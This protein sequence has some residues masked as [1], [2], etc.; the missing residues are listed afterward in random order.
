MKTKNLLKEAIIWLIIALP[1]GYLAYVWKDLPA[2]IPIHYGINGQPDNWTSPQGL[3]WLTLSM[4]LGVYLLM[5][6]I[7]LIDPKQKITKMGTKYFA[8]KLL[9]TAFMSAVAFILIYTSVKTE[10]KT[11]KLIAILMGF[12]MV[13][14]GN[15]MPSFKPNYFIGVR[16]PW[17][18][19]SEPN[20]QATHRFAGWTWV[21]TGLFVFLLA[22]FVNKHFV[23]QL[24]ILLIMLAA[25]API[26]YSF[27][28][29]LRNKN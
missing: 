27:I 24:S 12:L 20:W 26:V 18:L 13:V 5:C 29:Y 22:L 28:Y 14:F 25:L 10:I 8:V 16:T 19:E 21:T 2:Q 6:I 11:E 3:I 1:L 17:T 4:T 7:P 15:Y 9:M 23:Y